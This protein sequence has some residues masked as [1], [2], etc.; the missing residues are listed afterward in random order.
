VS[1]VPMTAK[2]YSIKVS[3]RSG[4]QYTESQLQNDVEMTIGD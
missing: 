2:F 1:D 3:H 4:P